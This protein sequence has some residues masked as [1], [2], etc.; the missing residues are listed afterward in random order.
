MSVYNREMLN[1]L[2]SVI[3]DDFIMTGSRA[4]CDPPPMDT[5]EDYVL[6]DKNDCFQ[7]LLTMGF[8]LTSEPEYEGGS[9]FSTWRMDE[10]NLIVTNDRIFYNRFVAATL[11]A[12]QRN[13]LIKD[14][15]IELF[16]EI[17][18]GRVPT[19]SIL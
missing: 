10:Y 15:R 19:N 14:D 18:Y 5:D 11:L 9:W 16:K 4:I 6:L 7:T 1:E 8:K 13:L 2:L 12:K 17:L 3:S